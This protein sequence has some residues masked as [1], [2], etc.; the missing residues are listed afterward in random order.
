MSLVCA[1]TSWIWCCLQSHPTFMASNAPSFALALWLALCHYFLGFLPLFFFTIAANLAYG[2]QKSLGLAGRQS[3]S[4]VL[5]LKKLNQTKSKQNLSHASHYFI[6]C[7]AFRGWS[8]LKASALQA[9]YPFV[10][11]AGLALIA[12]CPSL[13][14]LKKDWKTTNL[15]K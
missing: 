2:C 3:K 6:I 10:T 14:R 5:I 9:P 1:Q 12:L 15:L 11:L 8:M 7:E 4:L 13:S